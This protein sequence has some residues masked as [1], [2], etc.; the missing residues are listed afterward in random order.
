MLVV[1]TD[2]KGH[3]DRDPDYEKKKQKGLENLGYYFIINSDKKM[4]NDYEEFCRVLKYI[5]LSTLQILKYKNH[6]L[7]IFQKDC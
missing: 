7:M 2:E 6:W 3:A 4:F 1:E 5:T